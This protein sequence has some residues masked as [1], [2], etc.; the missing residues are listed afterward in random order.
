RGEGQDKGWGR[1]GPGGRP[2]SCRD[3]S[4]RRGGRVD[5][6]ARLIG[7]ARRCLA[8]LGGGREGLVVAVS[9]GPDS[10]AL[11]RALIDARHPE[12]T[13]LVLA[14]LNHRLRGPESDADEDFVVA[15]H[16][17][18]VVAGTPALELC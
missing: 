15:L 10:V 7:M 11:A 8:A 6:S 5:V 1:A 2:F 4:G 17:A 14:H 12:A 3:C 13:P 16:A 18:L 9:G